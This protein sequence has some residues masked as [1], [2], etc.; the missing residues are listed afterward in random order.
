MAA[1]LGAFMNSV[2][3]ECHLIMKEFNSI[4]KCYDWKEVA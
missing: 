4:N 2:S 1:V 3:I